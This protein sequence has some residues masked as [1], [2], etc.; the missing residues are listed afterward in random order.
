MPLAPSLTNED[1][2][3]GAGA[4]RTGEEGEACLRKLEE[5]DSR[6][7]DQ[8]AFASEIFQSGRLIRKEQD[9]QQT[10]SG[11]KLY[12]LCQFNREPCVQR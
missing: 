6:F 4:S 10:H 1:G 11:R 9:V 3:P 12:F 5:I 2:M 7:A 8:T